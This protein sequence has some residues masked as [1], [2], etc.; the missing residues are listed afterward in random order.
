VPT[1]LIATSRELARLQTQLTEDITR[2]RNEIH[3]L[4]QVLI[5]LVQPS[6]RGPVSANG[7][8]PAQTLSKSRKPSRQRVES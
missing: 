4:V 6:V 5:P 3:A 8:I 2:Y 7:F 1:D